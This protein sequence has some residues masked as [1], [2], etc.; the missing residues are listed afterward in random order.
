MDYGYAG[1]RLCGQ[2]TRYIMWKDTPCG[3]SILDGIR[4]IGGVHHVETVRTDHWVHLGLWVWYDWLWMPTLCF[5]LLSMLSCG[6]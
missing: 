5:Y 6:W 3:G 2:T 1:W 4:T